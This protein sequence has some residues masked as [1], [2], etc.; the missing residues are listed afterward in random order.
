MSAGAVADLFQRSFGA[1]PAVIAS[2]PGRVNLIGEHID[3]NGGEVLPIAITSRT[4]VALGPSGGS[5]S[6]AV[7]REE[8]TAGEFVNADGMPAGAWW[9]YVHGALRQAGC[10]AP[11]AIAVASDVPVGA[12]LSSSAALEVATVLAAWS[13]RDVPWTPDSVAMAAHRAER[14]FVGVPC[15]IMDQYASACARADHALRVWCDDARTAFVPFDRD[16]LIVDTGDPR[17]LR[18]SAF[19]DRRQSCEAA[20]RVLQEAS[21]GVRALAHADPQLV[22]AALHGESLRRARHVVSEQARVHRVVEA[23]ARGEPLGA[24]L[25]DSHRSLRDDYECSSPRLDWVV[26]WAMTRP[27]VDG[28]RLTGAGWGGCAIAVGDR[29]ALRDVATA[30]AT[31]FEARWGP[32][33]RTWITGAGDGARREG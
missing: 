23:L 9:D 6:R 2:A 32:A 33:P 15:G 17:H 18:S 20:L 13:W 10:D 8:T 16:V 4:F 11:V 7:S 25:L 29:G 27:E 1:A 26:E 5:R 14:D 19:A 31:A 3:Y 30:L 24:L 28:A 22:A 12:G 21:P